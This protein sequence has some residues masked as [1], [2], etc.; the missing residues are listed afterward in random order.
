LNRRRESGENSARISPLVHARRQ[1]GTL[2]E[3]VAEN[4]YAVPS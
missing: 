4:S 3:F 1:R 2:E